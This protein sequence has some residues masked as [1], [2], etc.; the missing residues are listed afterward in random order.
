[1]PK[2]KTIKLSKEKREELE[3]AIYCGLHLE[4]SAKKKDKGLVWSTDDKCPW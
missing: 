2:I 4:S 3:I 1:M